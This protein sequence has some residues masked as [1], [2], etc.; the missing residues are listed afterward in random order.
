MAFLPTNQQAFIIVVT[1]LKNLALGNTIVSF[2]RPEATA[3][4][5]VSDFIAHDFNSY[6]GANLPYPTGF[7]SL[8]SLI[9][10]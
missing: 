4:I 6:T 9:I 10:K 7:L 3:W 8:C 5:G 2:F 1:P